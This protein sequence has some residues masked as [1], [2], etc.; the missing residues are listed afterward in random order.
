MAWTVKCT[1]CLFPGPVLWSRCSTVLKTDTGKRLVGNK[2]TLA[3]LF[4]FLDAY[5]FGA[6][7]SAEIQEQN[8]S[9]INA[10]VLGLIFEKINGY[11]D[12]SGCGGAC[13]CITDYQDGGRRDR[14]REP[15]ARG[16]P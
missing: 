12:G 5:D 3:Y 2:S 11:R 14:S 9:I 6:E 15:A 8:K 4:E 7:G 16:R 1:T 13:S 10:A